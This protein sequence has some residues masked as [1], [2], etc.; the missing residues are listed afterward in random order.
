MTIK[1]HNAVVII[2]YKAHPTKD[3]LSSFSQCLRVL[4]E[5]PLFLI[6]P[7]SLNITKY[8]ALA[9]ALES[10]LEFIPLDDMWFTSVAQYNRLMLTEFFYSIFKNYN[11]ILIYQL[12][13]WVFSDNLTHWCNQGFAYIGAPWFTARNSLSNI[14]GNGGFS[15]RK[16]SLFIE[17]T[18]TIHETYETFPHHVWLQY[19]S[20]RN[21]VCGLKNLCSIYLKKIWTPK[22]YLSQHWNE[23][24]IFALTIYLQDKKLI[25]NAKIAMKF[26]FERQPEILFRLNKYM[27][28]FG[29]HAYTRYSQFFWKKFI[30]ISNKK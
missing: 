23:D 18:K 13:A 20:S 25:P 19:L 21:L 15:L 17:I 27:L 2:A 26:S 22:K 16:T 30:P 11:Y 29:C 3:E 28:P 6:Y 10:T 12:D 5:H 1:L 8:K 14:C 7:K 4:H 9:S 24:A